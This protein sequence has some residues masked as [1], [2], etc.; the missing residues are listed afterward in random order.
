MKIVIVGA[1]GT[2]GSAVVQALEN[3]H[4]I[5][6]AGRKDCDLPVDIE[7]E[8]Q[9]SQLFATIGNFDALISCTGKVTFAPLTEMNNAKFNLGIRNK[10]MGQINL[11]THALRYLNDAGSVTL[12]SGLLNDD[13]IKQGT[14]A[15]MVNGGLEGFVK[16]AAIDMPRR[17]RINLVSPC[18]IAESIENYAQFFPGIKPV[19]VSDVALAYVRSVEG[20]RTGS[21]FR[22]G[23]SRD[24]N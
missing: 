14:S 7:H 23:W 2:I 13:P 1:S 3:R 21:I 4:E 10:L 9:I 20:A 22:V 6:T 19:K 5:I 8:S 15:A 17:I 18:A 16:A 24:I 11:T 12:T